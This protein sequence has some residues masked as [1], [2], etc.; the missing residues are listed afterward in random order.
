M[1]FYGFG[2]QYLW[3]R[4][5]GVAIKDDELSALQSLEAEKKKIEEEN[6][7]LNLI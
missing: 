4:V 6:L 3:L 7:N 1:C 2:A 5:L